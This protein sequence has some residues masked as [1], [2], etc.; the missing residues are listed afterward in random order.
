[1]L[2][3]VFTEQTQTRSVPSKKRA[4]CSIPEKLFKSIQ[5]TKAFSKYFDAPKNFNEKMPIRKTFERQ[6]V[7]T[8]EIFRE[9]MSIHKKETH[10]D[11]RKHQRENAPSKKTLREIVATRQTLHEKYGGLLFC[12]RVTY[13]TIRPFAGFPKIFLRFMWSCMVVCSIQ[14][15]SMGVPIPSRPQPYRKPWDP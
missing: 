12:I 11:A 13:P 8:N 1:M 6:N 9:K 14:L 5:A 10:F 4:K 2:F 15:G 7:D 3:Q